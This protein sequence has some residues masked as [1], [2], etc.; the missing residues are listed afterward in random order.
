MIHVLLTGTLYG[1]PVRR[2]AR[3]GHP[4]ATAKLLADV[5]DGSMVWCSTIAFAETGE[6]L[7]TLQAGD[8]VSVTGK[9]RL[10]QWEDA[11][12]N[13]RAGLAVTITEVIA[14]QQASRTRFQ[15]PRALQ[16]QPEFS[17]DTAVP[18]DDDL[19]FLNAEPAKTD[20]EASPVGSEQDPPPMAPPGTEG[21]NATE[22]PQ[23]G[24]QRD[25]TSRSVVL[26][27]LVKAPRKAKKRRKLLSA[28]SPSP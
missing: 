28:P 20:A 2:I 10:S 12:G 15:K 7:A 13:P 16:P 26:K 8:A 18:F 21:R 23:D 17:G 4:F 25:G 27:T 1:P 19:D 11:E 9:A 6:R 24:L 22:K 14:L 3:N 5:G